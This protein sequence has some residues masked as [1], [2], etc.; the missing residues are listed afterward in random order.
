MIIY[1]AFAAGGFWL[2]RSRVDE[3]MF[4][5]ILL[6]LLPVCMV[7]WVA[8]AIHCGE[9]WRQGP[10]SATESLTMN[11][12]RITREEHPVSFWLMIIL[13]VM[14][15]LALLIFALL[16]IYIRLNTVP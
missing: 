11:E 8:D 5:L 2:I 16:G 9:I 12:R 6:G 13:T 10:K 7:S 1:A 3:A 14:F 4:S 15:A